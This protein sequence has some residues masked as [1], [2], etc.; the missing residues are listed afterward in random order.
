MYAEIFNN[1]LLNEWMN[2]ALPISEVLNA[3]MKTLLYVLSIFTYII[4]HKFHNK[5]VKK[6]TLSLRGWGNRGQEVLRKNKDQ[7]HTA[8]E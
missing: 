4:A 7:I 3:Y 2:G 6:I 5:P 1:Y 8:H